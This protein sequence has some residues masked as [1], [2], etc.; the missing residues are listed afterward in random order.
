MPKLQDAR[1]IV[2]VEGLPN[3]PDA[4]I[5]LRDGLLMGDVQAIEKIKDRVEQSLTILQKMITSWNFT[6]EDDKP[7]PITVENLKMLTNADLEALLSKVS[8][9]QDFLAKKTTQDNE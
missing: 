6:G 4:V 1:K 3:F 5:E 8:F 7:T 2:K 9:V